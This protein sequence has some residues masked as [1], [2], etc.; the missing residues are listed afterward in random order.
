M[1]IQVHRDIVTHTLDMDKMQ[2]RM[3]INYPR[4]HTELTATTTTLGTP[5]MSTLNRP[6][7]NHMVLHRI[8]ASHQIVH[9]IATNLVILSAR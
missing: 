8:P 1:D 3:V 2:P 5:N 7:T 6:M 9:Q 4:K